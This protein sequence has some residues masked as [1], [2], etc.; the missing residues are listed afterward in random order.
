MS[1][2]L[3]LQ[4]MTE[5]KED[6]PDIY[7]NFMERSLVLRKTDR[8]WAGLSSDLVIEQVLM[9]SL[10]S[11]GLTRGRR[12]IGNQRLVWLLSMPSCAEINLTMQELTGTLYKKK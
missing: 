5:L 1:V 9:R 6:H 3:Y 10:I 12:M 7:K 2:Y 8:Y 11:G 4:M